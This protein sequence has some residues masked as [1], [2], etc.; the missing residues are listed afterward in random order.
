MALLYPEMK[1]TRCGWIHMLNDDPDYAMYGYRCFRCG[2]EDRNRDKGI[3]VEAT[4]DE[5]PY[6]STVQQLNIIPPAG[7]PEFCP[8]CGRSLYHRGYSWECLDC[9]ISGSITPPTAE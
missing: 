1:C 8:Q 4:P 3:F 7:I 2:V 5:L 6:G 9:K